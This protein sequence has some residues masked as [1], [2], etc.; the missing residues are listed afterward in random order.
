MTLSFLPAALILRAGITLFGRKHRI[1]TLRT[2]GSIIFSG[3]SFGGMTLMTVG[4][5]HHEFNRAQEIDF[6]CHEK[7]ADLDDGYDDDDDA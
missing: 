7:E 1:M 4:G 3:V 5:K 6:V 2:S